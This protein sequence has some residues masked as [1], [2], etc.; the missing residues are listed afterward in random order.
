MPRSATLAVLVCLL[1]S[2]PVHA[3]VLTFEGAALANDAPV[4]ADYG[5][6]ID[7]LTRPVTTPSGTTTFFYGPAGGL[8]PDIVADYGNEV[9]WSSGAYGAL[10]FSSYANAGRYTLSLRAAPGRNV[11]LDSFDLAALGGINVSVDALG[12]SVRNAGGDLLFA[13][14]A[15]AGQVSTSDATR[16]QFQGGLSADVITIAFNLSLFTF[17]GVLRPDVVALS[18][19]SFGQVL[20]PIPLPATVILLAGAVV[21]TGAH[22]RRGN[23]VVGIS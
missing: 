1:S 9:R 19:V 6:N 14:L 3:A 2:L 11:R 13:P 18:N 5:D 4:L 12:L 23:R 20:V 16:F 7:A 22:L 15:G 10:A 21:C 17:N 8:T